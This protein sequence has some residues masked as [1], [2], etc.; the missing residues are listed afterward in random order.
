MG[1]IE[2]AYLGL[3]NDR[4]QRHVCSESAHRFFAAIIAVIV[5]N[6]H[7][8]VEQFRCDSTG[9]RG[10]AHARICC[11]KESM[12]MLVLCEHLAQLCNEFVVSLDFIKCG[13]VFLPK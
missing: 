10:L 12:R 4:A 11:D 1:F 5:F 8:R 13:S 9:E 3:A 7:L 6:D 2:D